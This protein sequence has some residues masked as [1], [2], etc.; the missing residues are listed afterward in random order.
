VGNEAETG[1]KRCGLICM[2]RAAIPRNH[3]FDSKTG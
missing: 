3:Y 2:G 1:G